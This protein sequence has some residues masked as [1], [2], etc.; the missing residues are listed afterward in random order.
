[1]FLYCLPLPGR[2]FCVHCV[3]HVRPMWPF[4]ATSGL[5]FATRPK[6]SMYF[7]SHIVMCR[8]SRPPQDTHLHTHLHT[9]TNERSNIQQSVSMPGGQACLHGLHNELAHAH[10]HTHYTHLQ[11][12]GNFSHSRGP[13]GQHACTA[14][15][16]SWHMQPTMAATEEL[17]A[18]P[19]KGRRNPVA[20]DRRR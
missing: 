5:N 17:S 6:T 7:S 20:P 4:L 19:L 10:R 9:D 1:M 11:P 12:H 15:T 13:G 16:T 14:C 2:L 18:P 3:A 8:L